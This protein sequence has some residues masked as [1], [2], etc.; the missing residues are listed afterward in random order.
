[1]SVELLE[2]I[3]Q[4]IGVLNKQQQAELSQFL[5]EQMKQD[6]ARAT[7][8]CLP[9]GDLEAVEIRRRQ[10]AEW[11]KSHR[12]E[13]GGMYVALDGDRLLGTGKNYPEAAAAARQ[14]AVSNA[15]VD[16]VLPPDYEGYMGG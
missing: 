16:F 5:Q 6:T 14:A 13:Y 2:T 12:E 10:H 7:A 3:K 9:S 11:M 8:P 1:M 4:Q 15:Y